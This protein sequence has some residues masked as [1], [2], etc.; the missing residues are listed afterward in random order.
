MHDVMRR[1][2]DRGRVAGLVGLISRHGEEYVDAIGTLAFD[3]GAPM[4]HDT[5]FRLASVT[6]PITAVAAMILVEECTLRL[7]DPVDAWLPELANRR[8]LHTIGSELDDTVPAKRAITLRDLLTFRSGYGEV[9][10]LSPRCR[11]HRAMITAQL[12]LGCAD[13]PRVQR[14]ALGVPTRAPLRT[15]GDEGHRVPRTGGP[16]RP[17]PHLLPRRMCR[18]GR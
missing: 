17:A 6:K 7:D 2:V 15:A 12:P 3:R 11:L 13:C 8:V 1:H 5:I 9:A 10:F 14:V 18:P 4:R 16:A